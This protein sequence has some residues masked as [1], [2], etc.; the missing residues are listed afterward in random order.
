MPPL[1]S[2]YVVQVRLT[3]SLPL[4][5]GTRPRSGQAKLLYLSVQSNCFREEH[6]TQSGPVTANIHRI[7]LT[8]PGKRCTVFCFLF[9]CLFVCL[10]IL[11]VL[12]RHQFYTHQCIHFNPNRPIQHTTIPTPP[13][14]SPLG[15][16]MSILY[17]CVS[18]SALQTGSSVPFF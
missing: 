7:L 1:F 15:V 2:D 6:L 3:Q 4:R 17:I 18:T 14:F 12:I 8:L 5:M 10:F 11:Q 13:Q 16:H 9:V